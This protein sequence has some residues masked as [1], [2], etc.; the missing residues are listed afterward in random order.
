MD[1][2]HEDPGKTA[3]PP[4]STR[5]RSRGLPALPAPASVAK[6]KGFRTLRR[7]D[8]RGKYNGGHGRACPYWRAA[9]RQRPWTVQR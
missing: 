4:G 6:V 2:Q 8:S 1:A 3:I 9:G 7:W 5:S